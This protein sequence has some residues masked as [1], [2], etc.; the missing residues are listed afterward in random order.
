[1]SRP[2]N[3][4]IGQKPIAMPNGNRQGHKAQATHHHA[5]PMR[6]SD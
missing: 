4:A 3:P 1:M 2:K 5:K 6:L